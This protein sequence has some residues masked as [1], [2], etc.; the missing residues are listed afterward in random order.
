MHDGFT[1]L[2]QSRLSLN[3]VVRFS[4]GAWWPAPD[5]QPTV[6]LS[7]CKSCRRRHGRAFAR[8][9]RITLNMKKL[10]G[11]LVL[12]LAAL[13]AQASQRACD[14]QLIPMQIYATGL[15][16]QGLQLP[17]LVD[18]YLPTN[19]SDG[20]AGM[21]QP[22]L[23]I[24]GGGFNWVERDREKIVEIAVGLAQAGFAVFPIEHRVRDWNGFAPVSET[25][26]SAEMVVYQRN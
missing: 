9:N 14:F 4:A 6:S 11:L 23:L 19:C 26:T 25:K 22:V 16:E 2:Q 12:S 1:N 17:L 20:P 13:G 8:V 10:S 7:V 24:P 21:V 3:F 15:L 18:S 5:W